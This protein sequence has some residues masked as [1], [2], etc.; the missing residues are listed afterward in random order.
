VGT[1]DPFRLCLGCAFAPDHKGMLPAAGSG[2]A[3]VPDARFV[4][5]DGCHAHK[6]E[7]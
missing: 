6:R 1:I 7:R 4:V 2:P 3:V 5:A